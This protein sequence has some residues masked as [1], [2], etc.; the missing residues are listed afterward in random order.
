[1]AASMGGAGTQWYLVRTKAGEE[2]RANAHL[3][4]FADEAFLPLMKAQV[5]RYSRLVEVI[6]PLF[7]CYLF[8]MFD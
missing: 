1:M 8:A 2:R 3:I 7:A 6:V 5:R 4:H